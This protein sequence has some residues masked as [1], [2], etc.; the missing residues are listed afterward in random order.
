MDR[1]ITVFH[2]E[3]IRMEPEFAK[4]L[5]KQIK[6]E[7]FVRCLTTAVQR[8]KELLNCDQ[9]TLLGAAMLA[10]QDG[11]LPDG[12]F[13]VIVPFRDKQT[14]TK[15][16]QWLPMIA[17]VYQKLHNSKELKSISATLVYEKD[18]FEFY[19]GDT[20]EIRHIPLMFSERGNIIG[21]YAIAK[22]M[23]GG[24]YREAM[25]KPEVEAARSKSKSPDSQAW[26]EWWGEM[27]KKT[28]IKRLAKRLPISTEDLG[29]M[30][31]E[32]EEEGVP[33]MDQIEAERK[34]QWTTPQIELKD[35]LYVPTDDI[36]NSEETKDLAQTK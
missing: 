25:S 18:L 5:P 17:G 1:S 27:A 14:G 33:G 10:A 32:D 15:I 35:D 16:A 3:L 26:S 11:L 2:G 8:N 12:R 24:T 22:T 28:V 23:N 29:W 30:Y 7:R 4:V 21:V 20:E 34:R 6:S 9:R 36:P 31:R 13:G 19:Q